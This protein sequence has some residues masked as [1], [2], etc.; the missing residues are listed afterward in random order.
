MKTAIRFVASVVLTLIA[1]FALTHVGEIRAQGIG[2]TVEAAYVRILNTSGYGGWSLRVDSTNNLIAQNTDTARA[3]LPLSEPTVDKTTGGI[4]FPGYT[5]TQMVTLA[6]PASGYMIWQTNTAEKS[7]GL[8]GAV[9]S[10]GR[11][12]ISTGSGLGAWTIY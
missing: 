11:M 2:P 7:N 12:F 4:K 10:G 5:V 9:G 8:T 3:I 1:A 6:A